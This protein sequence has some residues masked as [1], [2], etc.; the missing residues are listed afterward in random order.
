MQREKKCHQRTY[1]RCHRM[2][3]EH[4]TVCPCSLQE[5]RNITEMPILYGYKMRKEDIM[6]PFCRYY[7]CVLPYYTEAMALIYLFTYSSF[8]K[9]HVAEA[10][11]PIF[12][13][14]HLHVSMAVY[15]LVISLISRSVWCQWLCSSEALLHTQPGC[16]S[17]SS[18]GRSLRGSPSQSQ[19]QSTAQWKEQKEHL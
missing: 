17:S 4:R 19:L 9:I 1:F 12:A 7:V 15:M 14:Q 11:P 18:D 8:W 13:H 5:C 16:V 2:S 6:L 10:K 3:Q